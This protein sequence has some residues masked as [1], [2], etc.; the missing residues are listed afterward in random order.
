MR[1][2][3][4]MTNC[5]FCKLINFYWRIIALQNFA[6]FCQISTWISHWD[7][8][9]TSLLNLLPISLP[10]SPLWVDTETPFEFPKPYSKFLLPIYFTYG[11]TSFHVI[12][13]IHLTLSSP[14]PISI[15]LFSMS[16]HCCPVNKFFSTIFLYSIYMC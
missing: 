15:S 4:N 7:T 9:I 13:S 10:I 3:L 1:K 11:N 16:L 14:L 12:L 6:V 8:Y 2:I 5:F